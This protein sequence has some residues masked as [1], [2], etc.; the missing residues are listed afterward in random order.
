MSEEFLTLV[1]RHLEPGGVFFFN[2]TASLDACK[3]AMV[4]FPH[5]MR[6]INF[7]AG[8]DAPLALGEAAWRELLG[9][10]RIDAQPVIDLASSEGKDA[11]AKL[12]SYIRPGD[13]YA[14]SEGEATLRQRCATGEV[15][16]DDNMLPEWRSLWHREMP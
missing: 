3:T 16:T 8:S 1:K 13:G 6:V 4:A 12:A 7:M 10:Y 5:T 15:I 14:D 2:T 11:F 9:A